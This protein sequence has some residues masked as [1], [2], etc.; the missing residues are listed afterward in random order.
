MGTRPEIIKLFPLIK[1]CQ[2][3]EIPF[4]ILHTNQHYSPNMDLFFFEELGLPKPKYNLKIRA[5]QHGDMVGRMLGPIETILLKQK[6]SIVIVQ[7][8]TNTVLAGALAASKLN[9]PIG[10]VEAGLRSYDRSMPEEVNRVITDHVS[11]YLFCP[12]K[13]QKRI[14]LGE[15]IG[16]SKI[17]ITGNT[18]VDTI[19]Q[20]LKI[21]EQEESFKHYK[22]EIYILLTLHRPANVDD[23]MILKS[24]IK[25]FHEVS[26]KL[27]ATIYFPAHP[28]TARMIANCDITIDPRL[29]RLMNPVSYLEMIMLEKYA[30][31]ILT[32][33]GGL[34]EEACV[35]GVPCV[36][37]R[38]NTERPETIEV[39]ANTLG[40]TARESIIKAV[41]KMHSVSKKWRNPYGNG[42]AA[43]KI[44]SFLQNKSISNI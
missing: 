3:R 14:L 39:G 41:L 29:I 11:T 36:T 15:G 31:L 32:D 22:N 25:T 19:I 18:I 35:L 16:K 34:Q 13:K 21:A 1:L 40:G 42:Y 2:N 12:T 28:R 27:K 33:S 37:I 23:V 26:K 20:N 17:F 38:N 44:M 10:H 8:D 5:N 7:G 4:F 30:K 9:I 43:D 6:P 24:L